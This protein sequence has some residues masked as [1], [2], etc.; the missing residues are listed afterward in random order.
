MSL[1][2]SAVSYQVSAP[3]L[4]GRGVGGDPPQAEALM[5]D[6]AKLEEVCKV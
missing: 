6:L 5:A 1:Q 2:A 4:Y 3:P